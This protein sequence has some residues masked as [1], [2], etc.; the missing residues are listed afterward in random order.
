M[1]RSDAWSIGLAASEFEPDGACVLGPTDAVL[2]AGALC[3]NHTIE[4]L[5]LREQRLCGIDGRDFKPQTAEIVEEGICALAQM[6]AV[7][8]HI[9]ALNLSCNAIGP[10]T[11]TSVGMSKLTE[12]LEA[13]NESLV[14]LD[15][16]MNQLCGVFSVGNESAPERLELEQQ[17]SYT[18]QPLVALL[19]ALATRKACISLSLAD[20]GLCG[21]TQATR[22]TNASNG[23]V[24]K[25]TAFTHAFLQRFAELLCTGCSSVDCQHYSARFGCQM[26][27]IALDL[28]KNFIGAFLFY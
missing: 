15:L 1:L 3:C 2:L 18:E 22:D 10:R 12:V 17:G 5:C 24:G 11:G 7:N 21:Y 27:L 23:S 13:H 20:C 25:G 8:T 19:R 9:K 16:S 26:D 4:S 6:L 14:V 28:S